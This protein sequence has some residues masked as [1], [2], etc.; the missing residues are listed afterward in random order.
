[1]RYK[2][3]TKTEKAWDVMLEA[4]ERAKSSIL[5]EMYIFVDDT[6]DTHDFIEIL[7]SKASSG[8]SV[9]VILDSFGSQSLSSASVKKLR[10]SGVELFFFKTLFRTTHRKTLIIDGNTAFIG[11]INVRKFFKKWD[12]LLIK[13]E[14]RIVDRVLRSFA[15]IYKRCG[16]KDREVLKYDDEGEVHLE[17][18]KIWFFEHYPPRNSSKLKKYYKDKIKF[19]RKKILIITPYLMPNH[20]VVKS[21]KKAAKRGVKIEII[22]PRFATN[23]KLANIPNYLYMHK[24]NKYGIQFFLTPEMNHSKVMIVDDEEGIL[25]S[26][27][28]D[29][30]SFNFNMESG[31]FFSDQGLI[32]E[33]NQVAENWKSNSIIYSPDMRKVKLFDYFLTFCFGTFEHA[34]DFFNSVTKPF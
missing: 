29:I 9:K 16:G 3:Y 11:G 32:E 30:L 4:L 24:L 25:G 27:N 17:K 8:V 7:S 2:I 5:F 23:P 21:L 6:S 34:I 13:V 10:D 22:I 31:V 19:A 14:G 26:Q 33:I 20:W 15:R 18:G 1:M 12:D 28:M